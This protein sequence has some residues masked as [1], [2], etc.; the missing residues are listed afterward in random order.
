MIP[1]F[2][3]LVALAV[4]TTLGGIVAF[5]PSAEPLWVA[6]GALGL[7][8]FLG[9]AWL[10]WTTPAPD[11]TRDMPSVLS[12]QAH[13]SVMLR[14]TNRHR[15]TLQIELFDH[16]PDELET[17]DLPHSFRIPSG[18]E[19]V[20]E[21]RIHPVT[22]GTARFGPVEMRIASPL[23]L[24]DRIHRS[25]IETRVRIY[26]NFDA[27]RRYE[28]LA[29][30]HRTSQLGVHRRP[31]RGVGLEF[32][33]LREYRPGDALRQVDWKATSRFQ[34]AISREYQDGRDQR[35][36]LVL[37]CGRRVGAQDGE[38][39]HLDASLDAALLVAHVALRQGDAVGFSTLGG[40]QRWLA[41]RKG[42]GQIGALLDG[43]FDLHAQPRASD[44]LSAAA[45]LMARV[46]KRSLIVWISN[47]RDEDG[48]ELS[49]AMKLMTRRHLVMLA[50][51]RETVLDTQLEHPVHNI[52]D[53]TRTAAIHHYL[54][55][56]RQAHRILET[57][58]A[59]LLDATPEKLP[60]ALVN[61]Y[62]DIKS[63]GL[64]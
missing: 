38:L 21:Y 35:T 50:S 42:P 27:V 22:R 58:G 28:L 8:V 13:T 25:D 51:L 36:I 29:A 48:S 37:D 63:A 24:F 57:G 4:W 20:F 3:A 49:A 11:V 5:L 44:H 14:M 10:G 43:V 33:Q 53:A 64:L 1:G 2:R 62:L 12:M 30:E 60:V 16:V 18:T 41:P 6:L 9:D 54:H 59:L 15:R 17:Q 31:R 47:L 19:A 32:Q 39:S 56:R 45:Q 23:G 61:G 40:E 55:S 34:R 46:R 26:P 7:V 52:E